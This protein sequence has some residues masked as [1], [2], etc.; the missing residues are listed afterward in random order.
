MLNKATKIKKIYMYLF[1]NIY[2]KKHVLFRI[3]QKVTAMQWILKNVF[4]KN[5][6]LINPHKTYNA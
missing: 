3:S 5:L 1:V 2:T 4:C 6:I